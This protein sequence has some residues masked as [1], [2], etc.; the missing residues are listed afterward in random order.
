MVVRS[1]SVYIFLCFFFWMMKEEKR[2]TSFF[3][4]PIAVTKKRD[5]SP[6]PREDG[7]LHERQ[8]DGVLGEHR[9]HNRRL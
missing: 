3:L 8:N 5:V 6:I 4:F 9:H 2:P 7:V 1:S